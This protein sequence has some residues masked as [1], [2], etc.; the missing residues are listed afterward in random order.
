LIIQLN[1]GS[2]PFIVWV[3]VNGPDRLDSSRGARITGPGIQHHLN[4][5]GNAES[6]ILPAISVEIAHRHGSQ[7]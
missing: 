6:D 7:A 3:E 2:A 4:A 5:T 1:D